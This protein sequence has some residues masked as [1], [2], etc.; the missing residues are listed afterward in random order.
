MLKNP[1]F[2][3]GLSFKNTSICTRCLILQNGL[4]VDEILVFFL[5]FQINEALTNTYVLSNYTC[6]NHNISKI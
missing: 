6:Y 4:P 2:K 1:I 5:K 3:V